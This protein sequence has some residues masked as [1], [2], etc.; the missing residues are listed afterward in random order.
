MLSR[1]I[2]VVS[3]SIIFWLAPIYADT[4]AGADLVLKN[5]VVYTVNANREWA[6]AVAI[7]NG[8]IT[9]VGDD[10][11]VVG[12][13]GNT[14]EVIDLAGRMLMPGFH[15]SHMHPMS[16]G[17]RFLRCRLHD[18]E[19]PDEALEEI[20]K[21]AKGLNDGE[22]LH[23]V[24]LPDEVFSGNGPHRT[25]LDRL[26]PDHPAYITNQSGFNAWVN[27]PAL[28]EADINANMEDPAR[29]EIVRDTNNIPSGVLK[30]SAAYMVRR[31][32]PHYS[33]DN[34][35][36]A[37]RLASQMANS[38]GITSANEA[39][40]FERHLQAY[41][42]ADLEGEMTLRV[43]ASL[44]WQNEFGVKQVHTLIRQK[45]SVSGN[46]F[47]A[48]AVKLVIDGD[49]HNH[50][51]G[52]LQ[53]YAD[54]AGDRG[55]LVFDSHRLNEIITELDGA[56]FQVHMH[57]VGDR[58]VQVGLDAIES[59][60]NRNRTR[61]RRHQLAHIALIDPLDL[62]RFALLGVVADFQ[63]LW[64]QQG[65]TLDQLSKFGEDR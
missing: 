8:L 32:L 17:T 51:A 63:P 22:W 34:L 19:W 11:G 49:F 5:G 44:A 27:S 28:A 48:D 16:A 52:L 25:E 6:E 1:I 61:D 57:A 29:G 54:K 41:R 46:K 53:S 14:T 35:R 26:V 40:V 36:L 20:E 30:G 2:F 50:S 38:F 7:R 47:R 55:D 31:I 23:G 18:L 9:Y 10:E 33:E 62:P 56:D 3:L 21:C 12:H 59:A 65:F 64:A 45:R 13:V 39:K 4:V 43:Q 42:R 58:A 24:G 37:L 60:I 15:D